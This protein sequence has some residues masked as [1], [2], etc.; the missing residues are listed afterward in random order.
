MTSNKLNVTLKAGEGFAAPWVTIGGDSAPEVAFN[1]KAAIGD[2]QTS[3]FFA[4]VTEAAT[5]LKGFYAASDQ[6]GATVVQQYAGTAAAFQPTTPGP[7]RWEAPA[8]AAPQQAQVYAQAPQAGPPA[9]QCKHGA[10]VYRQS[11]PGAA[12]VWKA[13]MCPTPKGTPDQCEAVWG[14]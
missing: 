14:R 3:E 4:L 8:P 12:N 13:H 6:L 7:G 10:M 2:T 11:K 1:L 5:A 9:P